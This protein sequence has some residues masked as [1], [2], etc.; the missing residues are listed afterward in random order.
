MKMFKCS[1]IRVGLYELFIDPTF[2]SARKQVAR[3]IYKRRLTRI[4]D[5]CT[6]LGTLTGYIRNR[7]YKAHGLDIDITKLRR[8]IRKAG[9]HSLTGA[10]ATKI[11]FKDRL[12]DAVTFTYALHD[13]DHDVRVNILTEAARVLKPGGRIIA[14]DY[15]PPWDFRSFL[16]HCFRYVTEAFSGHYRNGITFI[17]SGGIRPV[18]EKHGFT[19]ETVEKH[20]RFFSAVLV[21]AR[22][23][24]QQG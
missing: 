23:E 16:G 21:V 9:Y 8:G 19:V 2:R 7:E 22:K 18:F 4:L 1:S 12:F 3:E 6:A 10:D 17:R 11:P 24:Q 13:K 15:A 14:V 20:S 5:I